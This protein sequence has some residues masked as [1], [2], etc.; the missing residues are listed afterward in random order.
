MITAI[1]SAL[2]GLVS[3]VVPDVIKEV[4]DSRNHSREREFLELQHKF[5][6]ERLERDAEDKMRAADANIVGEELRAFAQTVTSIVEAQSK[7]TGIKWIDGFNAVLRPFCTSAIIFMFI[8]VSAAYVY[9]VMHAFNAG[10]IADTLTL[11]NLIWGSMIGE[12]CQAVLGF[13][14]GYR[15]AAKR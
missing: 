9:G 1:I 6:M 14:F 7:P 2:V 15:A 12:A 11:A 3:G 4:R 5:Q 10:Q 13:L 8:G